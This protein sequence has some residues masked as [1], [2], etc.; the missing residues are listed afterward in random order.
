MQPKSRPWWPFVKLLVGVAILFYVGRRFALDLSQPELYTQ[1]LTVGWLV[2]SG[3]LYLAGIGVPCIYWGWLL[4]QLGPR[5]DALPLARAY[6]VGQLGKY[7]PGKALSLLMRAT[8]GRAAGVSPGVAGMTAFYE[9]LVTMG[10]GALLA[11]GIYSVLTWQAPPVGAGEAWEQ[12]WTA[13]VRGTEPEGGFASRALRIVAV[14]LAVGVL[15]P[16]A[17]PIFNRLADRLSLPFR[18]P[19]TVLPRLRAWHLIFGLLIGTTGWVLLG[20][21]LACS[22]H[23]AA[24]GLAWDAATLARL[25]GILAVGYVA[26]F[27]VLVS[28]GG[29]G[30]RELFL[31]WLLAPE[32]AAAQD[33][34]YKLASGK[35]AL[36]VLLMRL[37]WTVA[38]VVAAAALFRVRGRPA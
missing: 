36:V 15:W 3:L 27:V 20:L 21:A 34:P 10:S 25:T 4:G 11:A 6:Y 1:P 37:A 16:T 29:L 26:G 38:E 23:G 8:Y 13:V 5:P 28:P 2:A 7:V 32:V 30:A 9:V 35:V 22:L 33:L 31:T 24:V 17:P 14:A 18:D 19:T 12:A